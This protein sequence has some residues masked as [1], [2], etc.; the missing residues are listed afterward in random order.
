M[1]HALAAVA[2]GLGLVCLAA[3][4]AIAAPGEAPPRRQLRFSNLTV[5]RLNP[6]GLIERVEA[7]HRWRLY[8]SDSPVT[9]DNFIGLGGQAI[10]TPALFRVGPSIEVQ[11]LSILSLEANFE[12]IDYFGSFDFFQSYRGPAADW[13]DTA[14]KDGQAYAASGTQL[15]LIATLRLKLGPIAVRD[16]ARF[17][18]PD[19]ALRDG[20]RYYYDPLWDLLI[21]D[22]TW[23]F[24]NDLDVLYLTDFG[25]RAGLRWTAAGGVDGEDRDPN[26]GPGKGANGPTHRV[27]PFLTWTFDSDDP[28]FAEPTL[29][30][31]VNWWLQHRFRTGAD[32]SAA[33]PYVIFGLSFRGELWSSGTGD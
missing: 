9:R 24:N 5:A 1:R 23:F 4:G 29:I 14:I 15:N 2:S 30:L 32:V 25:L 17:A 26:L 27:G 21:E 8:R 22:E 18:R 12:A 16:I 6:L 13:S 20:D 7:T 31:I 33:V 11:P 10:L 28:L 19:Y 3:S